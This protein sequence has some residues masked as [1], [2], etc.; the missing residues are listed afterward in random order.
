[1][2]FKT[3]TIKVFDLSMTVTTTKKFKN[4]SSF[5][6]SW[7]PEFVALKIHITLKSKVS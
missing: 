3:F 1:M 6:N 5:R 4:R 2:T 7:K